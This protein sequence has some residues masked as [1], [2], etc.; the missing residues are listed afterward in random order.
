MQLSLFM[1]PT[2]RCPAVATTCSYWL[3]PEH[4]RTIKR[5][6]TWSRIT[7]RWI[8]IWQSHCQAS[9]HE[10]ATEQ[11]WEPTPQFLFSKTDS[12]PVR[13]KILNNPKHFND[14]KWNSK[15]DDVFRCFIY[16]FY[17]T[18]EFTSHLKNITF[19]HFILTLEN[20]QYC[21]TPLGSSVTPRYS[22]AVVVPTNLLG[23]LCICGS[24]RSLINVFTVFFSF[25]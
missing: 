6:L 18:S 25:F 21:K 19:S 23:E 24:C 11:K 8:I 3:H 22:S 9:L 10:P 4:Q 7:Q 17:Q 2:F 5:C 20:C 13:L 1:V 16:L 14:I 12:A 15:I